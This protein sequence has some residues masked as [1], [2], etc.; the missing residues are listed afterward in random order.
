MQQSWSCPL[1]RLLVEQLMEHWTARS[2]VSVLLFVVAE[3][4]AAVVAAAVAAAVAVAVAAAVAAAVVFL[5]LPDLDSLVAAAVVVVEKLA[6]LGLQIAAAVAA[7]DVAVPALL[8]VETNLV[9]AE[10]EDEFG[11]KTV[12]EMLDVSSVDEKTDEF[13]VM[14]PPAAVVLNLVAETAAVLF[15]AAGLIE[16]V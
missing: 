1:A 15:V 10:T 7:V 9:D 6:V 2:V 3:A 16:A 8:L 11:V 14:V 5:R 4:A 12:G 13:V